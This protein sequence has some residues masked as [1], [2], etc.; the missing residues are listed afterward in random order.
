MAVAEAVDGGG[1]G[2]AGGRRGCGLRDEAG[3]A[4]PVPVVH[5]P[6]RQELGA[7][8]LSKGWQS[9]TSPAAVM[10]RPGLG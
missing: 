10:L 6:R 7:V 9:G 4:A 2:S 8:Q 5:A 1:G 3:R